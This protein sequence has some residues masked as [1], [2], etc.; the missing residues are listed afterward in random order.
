MTDIRTSR[1]QLQAIDVAE[2]ERIVARSAGPADTWADY[3]APS[4]QPPR[5]RAAEPGQRSGI[6]PGSWLLSYRLGRVGI[7]DAGSV[8]SLTQYRRV[9]LRE[10]VKKQFSELVRFLLGDVVTAVDFLPAHVCRPGAPD[11]Q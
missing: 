11:L 1:L 9:I 3:D 2:A 8:I 5:R 6:S 10:E 4:F 7:D